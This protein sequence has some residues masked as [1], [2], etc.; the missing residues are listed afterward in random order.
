MNLTLPLWT[1]VVRQTPASKT[2][3]RP[4]LSDEQWDLIAE[5]F[6]PYTPS[7]LGGR[8]PRPPRDCLEGIL[9]LLRSGAR[10]KDLPKEFPSPTT[11]WRRLQEW[12]LSGLFA[13]VWSVLLEALDDL[14]EIDWR[15]ALADGTFARAK[16]GASAWERPS[17]AREARSCS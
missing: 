14:D 17:A 3:R 15:E 2:D 1:A 6:P 10:W 16:K 9:W 4:Q 13:R 12:S 5:F 7:P 11:C 8:P